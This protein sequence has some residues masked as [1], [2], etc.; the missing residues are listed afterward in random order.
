MKKKLYFLLAASV[1]MFSACSSDDLSES[2][3][4]K[5]SQIDDSAVNFGAYVNRGITRAGA[6]GTLTTDGDPV[7]LKKVGF[8]VFA[9]YSD[10]ESYS[11]T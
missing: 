1:A 10:S 7:S 8:G 4:A 5:S 3:S 11:E 9:Y 6:A 2:S